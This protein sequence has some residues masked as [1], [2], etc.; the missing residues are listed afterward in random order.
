VTLSEIPDL[1][2]QLLDEPLAAAGVMAKG[3]P[4]TGSRERQLPI[5][6][7]V[8][9]LTHEGSGEE[10]AGED[11][12]GHLPVWHTLNVWMFEWAQRR[13][14]GEHGTAGVP[15]VCE[16][17][18][19]RVDDA[20]DTDLSIAEFFT[21]IRRLR[22]ALL[23]Q[24]GQVDVPDYKRGVPCKNPKCY[25]LTLVHHAGSDRIECGSCDS[26]LTFE[27]FDAWVRLVAAAAKKMERAA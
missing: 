24:L 19:E 2:W 1:W 16:W 17:L 8:F 7:D 23:G 21:S 14:R 3:G 10:L 11:Q 9:D 15:E 4:V 12:V 13:D 6:V 5:R 27:E 18:R 25:A 22:G 26:L 20:C